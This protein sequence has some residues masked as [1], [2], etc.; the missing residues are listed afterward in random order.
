MFHLGARGARSGG[1]LRNLIVLGLSSVLALV[2]VASAAATPPQN[3][4]IAFARQL[5]GGGADIFVANPDGQ[6]TQ[7]GAAHLSGGGLRDSALVSRW[8]PVAD[9]ARSPL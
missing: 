3:G 8:Q 7:P 2:C 9:L 5:P 1:S 4:E 6:H